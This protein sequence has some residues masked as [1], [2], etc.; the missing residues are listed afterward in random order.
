M[1]AY[2]FDHCIYAGDCT[3]DFYRYCLKKK[4]ALLRYLPRQIWGLVLYAFGFIQKTAFKER[5][6]SFLQGVEDRDA[7][8]TA[9]WATHKEKVYDW[10]RELQNEN[11]LIISASPEFLLEPLMNRLGLALI[12]SRVVPETGVYEGL[13]CH[14]EEK[15]RRMREAEPETQIDGFYSDSKSDTPLAKLARNAFM[16]TGDEISAFPLN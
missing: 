5:F 7:L 16:V 11:D 4:T 8:I 12:A 15:V 10:Y 2:D 3:I 9:F 14:G 13:N 1:N 6:F